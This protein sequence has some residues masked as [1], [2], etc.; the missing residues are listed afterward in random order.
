M[1]LIVV[2]APADVTVSCGCGRLLVGFTAARRTIGMPLEMPPSI[3][4]WRLVRVA[5]RTSPGAPS[6]ARKK[7]SLFSIPVSV[8]QPKPMPYSTPSTAGRLNS[9]LPKSAFSLS[10]TGSPQ[11]GGTPVATSSEMPPIESR[12][13]R[14]RSIS[15]AIRAAASWSGQRTGFA[16]TWSSVTAAGSSIRASMSPICLT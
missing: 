15:S 8:A 14:I 12:S 7:A 5:I 3:P 16:S 13:E 4:P 6:S 9:A 2:G 1:V 11:P 10:K